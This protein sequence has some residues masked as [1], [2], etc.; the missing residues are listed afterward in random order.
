MPYAPINSAVYVAAFTGA[1]GGIAIG[2]GWI[3][4][5]TPSDYSNV[6]IIAGAYAQ[7]VDIAWNNATPI[8]Q[9]EY[10]KI[11]CVSEHLFT[12]RGVQPAADTQFQQATN[13]IAV[14]L[15]V[16]ALVQEADTFLNGQGI[17]LPVIDPTGF[18]RVVNTAG[19]TALHLATGVYSFTTST[20][21]V[22]QLEQD[23]I[24]WTE[25]AYS[26][27]QAN[28]TT[29]QVQWI[30]EVPQ[31]WR[32]ETG[33][34][35]RALGDPA[36]PLATYAELRRRR[37]GRVFENDVTITIARD[38]PASD[39]FIMDLQKAPSVFPLIQGEPTV[40]LGGLSLTAYT[41]RNT[42]TN[43]ANQM[44]ASGITWSNHVD[45]YLLELTSGPANTYSCWMVKDLGA[46][47]ARVS[48]VCTPNGISS[49][50][51]IETQ[52]VNGDTFRVLRLPRIATYDIRPS[53]PLWVFS[54][55][56]FNTAGS[57]WTGGTTFHYSEVTIPPVST[58]IM[59]PIIFRDCSLDLLI[60]SGQYTLYR[61]CQTIGINL[62]LTTSTSFCAG[63]SIGRAYKFPATRWL[64]A[65]SA[66]AS[67]NSIE[68]GANDVQVLVGAIF[69][70]RLVA[71]MNG[72]YV[73][74]IDGAVFDSAGPGVSIATAGRV[75]VQG[76]WGNG[77]GTHGLITDGTGE[78]FTSGTAKITGTSGDVSVNAVPR[79]WA[80]LPTNVWIGTGRS[81]W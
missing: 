41:P 76:M 56:Y 64:G 22:E 61:N 81:G 69:Q 54:R 67:G 58:Q 14:A 74:W 55:L 8:D 29:G 25:R 6:C 33:G 45:G 23:G 12:H 52:P 63:V 15:G 28:G 66:P 3:T 77:N 34:D 78:F 19:R 71:V 80:A 36:H 30:G 47:I 65:T 2:S 40:A 79:T 59:R 51:S 60:C 20:G 11:Q 39:P 10:D 26:F 24:T 42:A 75:R 27:P 68:L 73:R 9:V 31:D 53:S 13:W 5:P 4:D 44:T 62:F 38:L 46:G 18:V 21:E 57:D 37:M 1:L 32:I 70:G 72:S 43:Q 17:I 35:D 48:T 7:A 49:G 16:V 50:S